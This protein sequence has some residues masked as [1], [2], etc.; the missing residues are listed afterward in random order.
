MRPA[1][2]ALVC[3]LFHG[4]SSAAGPSLSA[5]GTQHG[6]DKVA[7]GFTEVYTSLFELHRKATKLGL[8]PPALDRLGVQRMMEIGVFRGASIKMWRDWLP[9]ATIYGVDAFRGEMGWLNKKGPRKGKPLTF[10]GFEDFK[11]EVDAGDHGPRVRVLQAD[12]ANAS[13]MVAMA[14]TLL[15]SVGSS[16][17]LIVDDGSH[18]FRD[19][20]ES[21]SQLLPLVRP[22]GVYVIEDTHSSLQGG[23]DL[24]SMHPETTRRALERWK[25]SGSLTSRYLSGEQ[26]AEIERWV[27]S[28][29]RHTS[30]G[31]DGS[32]RSCETTIFRK[33]LGPRASSTATATGSAA[34]GA[35]TA[36]GDAPNV[37][38][39]VWGL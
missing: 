28:W 16:F 1:R 32:W 37:S 4:A 27:E 26:A 10:S 5:L 21:L 33:R 24:P 39:F 14:Q 34:T 15:D 20:L 35:S 3:A 23:Y 9:N 12:Q 18:K 7:Q 36:E 8:P 13:Q 25:A 29:S 31:Q 6:T 17:D 19:Q 30:K 2:I 11:R 38:Y 22:G